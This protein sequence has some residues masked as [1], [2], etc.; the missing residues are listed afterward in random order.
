MYIQNGFWH[1][2][3]VEESRY[4][5]TFNTPFD[6]YR[7]IRMPFGLCSTPEI[8]QRRMHEMEEGMTGIEVIANNFLIIG[9]GNTQE[10]IWEHDKVLRRF[11]VKCEQKNLNLYSAKLNYESLLY[12]I[13][14]TIY[15]QM[16]CNKEK[17]N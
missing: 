14:D 1:M 5:T 2:K 15:H 8:F 12:L 13:L 16:D 4:L 17:T 9:C 6:R 7:W 3:L 10:A 11:V